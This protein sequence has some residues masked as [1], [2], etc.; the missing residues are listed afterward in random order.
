[1]THARQLQ[2]ISFDLYERYGLLEQI[3]KF[4]RPEGSTYRV[5]DVG[6]CRAAFWP[7]L[8]SLAGVLIP[9]ASAVVADIISASELENYIQASGVHLPFRD[10]TFDLVCALDTLVHIPGEYRPAF[11]AEILRVI[12][13]WLVRIVSVRLRQAIAGRSR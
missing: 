8:T 13:G 11:L 5:L 1:M 2:E 6:G 7:G 3:G 10:G 4:F 12:T 9:D